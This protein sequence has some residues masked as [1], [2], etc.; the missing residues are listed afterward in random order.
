MELQFDRKE[1]N[2][3]QLLTSRVQNQ[4]LTQEVRLP[5]GMPDIG[6]VLGAWAQVL[7]RSKEWRDDSI[8]ISGGAMAWVLYSPE[9]EGAP[10][11]VEAW[12][13]FQMKWELPQT[14]RDGTIRV[15][16]LVYSADGR[17][18]SARKLMVRVGISVSG[19]AMAPGVAELCEPPEMPEDVQLLKTRY[20]IKIPME[21]G[22]K[23]FQ[24]DDDL[25]LPSGT[26]KPEKIVYY[27]VQ[28]HVQ[29]SKVLSDKA[30]FR[31]T[32]TVHLLFRGTGGALHTVNVELPF[33]QYTEL[34]REYGDNAQVCVTCALSNMELD[35]TDEDM[36]HFR[37]GVIGQYVVYDTPVVEL[38]EDAYSP[39][40]QADIQLEFLQLPAVISAK[41][42]TLQAE[43]ELPLSGGKLIEQAFYMEQPEVVHMTDSAQLQLSGQF[44][45]LWQ[46]ENG[47][48]Q[49]TVGK[50]TQTV[51]PD[52][53]E[54]AT[55]QA[56]LEPMGQPQTIY[57]GGAASL[58]T[59]LQL[60][61]YVT[62]HRGL[63]MV[64]AVELGEQKSPDP[65]RPSLI[66]RR[67]GDQ[68][69][70]ELA[71]N[72]GSTVDA[73]RTANAITDSQVPEGFLLIPV[74]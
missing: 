69:L 23:I 29:D 60:Q 66:L 22:E 28:P 2:C 59:Q 38:V 63:P 20:P 50:W 14:Q 4:E 7:V 1:L 26:E 61:T 73:I 41:T 32:A 10:C 74:Q 51:Q 8:R 35:I 52:G 13:P 6:R 24:V 39:V 49:S 5:D 53:A 44:Q 68:T 46:D 34:D 43:Q 16:P 18:T 31:G 55:L 67:A 27:S 54:S 58:Q 11:W 40:R 9:G 71:K 42:E 70:W 33:S 45:T 56:I 48:F 30:V 62:A 65:A 19:E 36:L 64:T 57:G 15:M 3:L 17:S 25:H 12:L 21:A 72:C 37:A 47:L